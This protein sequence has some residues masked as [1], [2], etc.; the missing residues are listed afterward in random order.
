MIELRTEFRYTATR[1]IR[2][3][4]YFRV[5]AGPTFNG[6]PWGVRGLFRFRAAYLQQKRWFV[7]ADEIERSA[8]DHRT[9]RPTI[10]RTH[11]LF[12]AGPEFP[13]SVT[14]GVVMQPYRIIRMRA[15]TARRKGIACATS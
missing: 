3:G 12:V 11:T 7:I 6:R 2:E 15:E 8:V 9:G 5:L 10:S 14:P 13:S 4:D 1:T